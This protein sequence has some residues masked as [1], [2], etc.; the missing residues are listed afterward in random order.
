MLAEYVNIVANLKNK[1]KEIVD[2]EEMSIK[3]YEKF[4]KCRSEANQ[5][6]LKKS[7]TLK[8]DVLFL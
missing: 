6:S 5:N 3:A 4:K 8:M 2:H 7:K 1:N